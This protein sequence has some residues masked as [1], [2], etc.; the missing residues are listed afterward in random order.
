MTK[1]II[2][3]YAERSD[4]IFKLCHE[5]GRR[6]KSD[7]VPAVTKSRAPSTPDLVVH[8]YRNVIVNAEE[9]DGEKI[10]MDNSRATM[11]TDKR[12]LPR[13]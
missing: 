12:R 5:Q 4:D 9:R 3:G 6:I 13:T 2:C 11:Q 1:E 8:D 7:T 10:I